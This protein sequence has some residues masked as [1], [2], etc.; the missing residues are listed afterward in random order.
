MSNKLSPWESQ[1][2]IIMKAS[3]FMR[4]EPAVYEVVSRLKSRAPEAVS[5]ARAMVLLSKAQTFIAFSQ[6]W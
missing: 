2:F 4:L 1:L 5:L 3:G 6:G